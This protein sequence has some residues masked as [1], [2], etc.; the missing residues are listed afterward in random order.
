MVRSI[1]TGRVVTL[2]VEHVTLPNGTSVDLEVVRHPGAAAVAAVDADGC[3]VLISQYRYAAGGFVW[4]LPAGVLD[5]PG[6]P[7]IDCAARELREETGL[8][9]QRFT[10]LGCIMPTC[11]YS[12]ERIHLFLAEGLRDGMHA[13]EHD[14]VI[15]E[16]R[17]V[18]LRDALGMARAGEVVDAKTVAGLFLAAARLGVAV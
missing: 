4:E 16:I 3:V 15:R 12:D 13:Q 8:G 14:E 2:N 7:P 11:G 10:A 18:P 17:R 1:Y 5:H 6:E 9:A